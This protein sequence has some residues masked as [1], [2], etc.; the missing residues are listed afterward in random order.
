M[1]A[2]LT[3][4]QYQDQIMLEMASRFRRG[5]LFDVKPTA[6]PQNI[7]KSFLYKSFNKWALL[8]NLDH[9][10]LS[11]PF[12]VSVRSATQHGLSVKDDATPFPIIVRRTLKSW[13]NPDW[14]AKTKSGT[15]IQI[16]SIHDEQNVVTE[17]GLLI[18]QDD[19]VMVQR[20]DQESIPFRDAI[21]AIPPY[22]DYAV[23][24]VYHISH[25]DGPVAG[26]FAPLLKEDGPNEFLQNIVK[27]FEQEGV[28]VTIRDGGPFEESDGV[29]CLGNETTPEGCLGAS[30]F[31][32]SFFI[33]K[34]VLIPK[35]GPT[36]SPIDEEAAL[37]ATMASVSFGLDYGLYYDPIKILTEERRQRI[38]DFLTLFPERAVSAFDR[39]EQAM[40]YALSKFSSIAHKIL[41]EKAS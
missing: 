37:I 40:E 36:S 16:A 9:A 17:D 3:V 8:V 41:S 33:A 31:V 12:F 25:C 4:R 1:T 28:R 15:V 26:R 32:L 14:I 13:Q 5:H 23:A 6:P 35:Q 34:N 22:T 27:L 18:P 38:A 20:Y 39:S 10:G 11:D 19:I 7:I 30:A 24:P 29:F 2:P 21:Y